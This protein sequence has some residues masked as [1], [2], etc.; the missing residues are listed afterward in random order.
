MKPDILMTGPM[1][2]P[3]QAVLESTYT[4]H[5][6]WEAQDRDAFLASVADRIT[7]CASTGSKGVDDATLAKLPKL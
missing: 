6:L 7:A 3:T 2:K 1:Y 5:K 4:T